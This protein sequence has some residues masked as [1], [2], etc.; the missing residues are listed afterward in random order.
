[1]TLLN[2]NGNLLVFL[3]GSFSCTSPLITPFKT[4][5]RQSVQTTEGEIYYFN[6]YTNETTWDK[7]DC[8]KTEAE[9]IAEGKVRSFW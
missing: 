8:L 1:M 3:F 4:L 9:L 2:Q 5:S 6:I 7:P